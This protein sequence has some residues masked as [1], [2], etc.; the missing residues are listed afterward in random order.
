MDR[1]L[2]RGFCALARWVLIA[3]FLLLSLIPPGVMPSRAADGTLVLVLC[4][5]E[6]MVEQVIDLATGA[7][8]EDA[9]TKDRA[10]DWACGQSVAALAALPQMPPVPLAATRLDPPPAPSVLH[11][12]LATGLPPATGP[13]AAV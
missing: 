3:P 13:S 12:A 9:P 6:G 4:T 11:A 1:G 8:V 10:C 7:P 2:T 5:G